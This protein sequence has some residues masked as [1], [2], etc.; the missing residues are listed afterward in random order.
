MTINYISGGTGIIPINMPSNQIYI[1]ESGNYIQTGTINLNNC[2]TIIGKTGN[3]LLQSTE[4]LATGMI[5]STAKQFN[6]IDNISINGTGGE[7]VEAHTG[8][9]YGLFYTST[10]KNNTINNTKIYNNIPIT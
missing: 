3:I 2:T 1:L 7:N 5:Y 4:Y 9:M 6:I 10:S 8:N